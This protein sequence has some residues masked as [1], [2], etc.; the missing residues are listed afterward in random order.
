MRRG[1][2]RRFDGAVLG[3]GWVASGQQS[4][5]K[6]HSHVVICS[7]RSALIIARKCSCP[8]MESRCFISSM[9][10]DTIRTKY[11]A[12]GQDHL[13]AFFPS[14]S[15]GERNALVQQLASIDVDRVNKIYRKAVDADK[16]LSDP[17]RVA[18]A[19]EPLPVE[20]CESVVNNPASESQWRQAGLGAIARGEVGVLLM[21]G[22]QGTRLGSSAP[23][24]C[25]DI[26]LPSHKSLFQYQAERIARLQSV[27]ESECDKPKGSVAI[28]WYV[29]TSGPTRKET[30]AF[31]QKNKYFGLHPKN[32]VIFEQG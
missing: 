1:H 3:M 32:V 9:A 29:M 21:A 31:F 23:K 4:E 17:S 12:A 18:D 28:P 20:A 2:G 25:Y 27:A 26:G 15:D 8:K 13:F 7:V 22:G 30:E 14:L 19:I 6:S 16:E 11:Q 24:G 10:A 5:E